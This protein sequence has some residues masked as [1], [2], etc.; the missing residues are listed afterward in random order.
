MTS[1]ENCPQISLPKAI[2]PFQDFLQRGKSHIFYIDPLPSERVLVL[3][4]IKYMR[5]PRYKRKREKGTQK[6]NTRGMNICE[7]GVEKDWDQ[8]RR[9]IH[10]FV[11]TIRHLRLLFQFI[12]SEAVY[13]RI[14]NFSNL[15]NLPCSLQGKWPTCIWTVNC[16]SYD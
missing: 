6:K 15:I 8:Y 4:N 3:P 16:C 14:L 11:S 10:D 7:K 9:R 13:L 2:H 1:N 5:N 12:C